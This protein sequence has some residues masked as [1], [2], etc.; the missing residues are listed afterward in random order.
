MTVLL[1][2]FRKKTWNSVINVLKENVFPPWMVYSAKIP[3]NE[4][5]EFRHFNTCKIW[6]KSPSLG[7]QSLL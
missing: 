5:I 1:N 3:I 4:K 7:F 6:K 2:I